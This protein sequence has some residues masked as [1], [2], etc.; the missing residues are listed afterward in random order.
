MRKVVGADETSV[1]VLG[2]YRG[3]GWDRSVSEGLFPVWFL[4]TLRLR[5]EV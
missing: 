2:Q 5:V 1:R 4:V 3:N